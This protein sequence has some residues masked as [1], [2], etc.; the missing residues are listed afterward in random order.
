[1]TE[2]MTR[3]KS[4]LG[5]PGAGGATSLFELA[6]PVC[7]ARGLDLVEAAL[8]R[9]PGG[10]VLRVIIDRPLPGQPSQPGSAVTV[11]DCSDVSRELSAL[12][13]AR[14]DLLAGSYRLEVTSPGLD[15]PL[16]RLADFERFKGQTARVETREPIGVRKRF[17][18]LL[19]GVE[20][21]VVRLEQDGEPVTIPHGQIKKANLVYEF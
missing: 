1:M 5:E 17:R 15:R 14:D 12:L 18:G 11:D 4:D 19:L 3:K 9:E 16:V 6:H 2:E 7:A 21:D 13:D 8:V 10:A 20:N